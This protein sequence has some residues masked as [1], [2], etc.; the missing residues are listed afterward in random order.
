MKNVAWGCHCFRVKTALKAHLENENAQPDKESPV[1][2]RRRRRCSFSVDAREHSIHHKIQVRWAATFAPQTHPFSK[3]I[4]NRVGAASQA[5]S[6]LCNAYD[7]YSK[8]HDWNTVRLL[9]YST[10][11]LVPRNSSWQV[12]FPK[13][14]AIYTKELPG[15]CSKGFCSKSLR[16]HSDPI[17]VSLPQRKGISRFSH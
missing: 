6:P 9:P 7:S 17:R 11:I 14:L 13:K 2:Q 16:V 3:R 8:R 5:Q 12:L 1:H 10:G 4:R 15:F